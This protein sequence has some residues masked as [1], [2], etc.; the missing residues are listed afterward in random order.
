MSGNGAQDARIGEARASGPGAAP[1][2]A[3][4]TGLG[5]QVRISTLRG[6]VPVLALVAGDLVLTR[7]SGFR[8]V[9][10][11]GQAEHG[12]AAGRNHPVVAVT[13][14]DHLG[15]GSADDR[16]DTRP[17]A[18]TRNIGPV[19]VDCS[20]PITSVLLVLDRHS[21]VLADGSWT[22]THSPMQL[23]ALVAQAQAPDIHRR[24]A[25]LWRDDRP[26]RLVLVSAGTVPGIPGAG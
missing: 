13:A 5:P 14:P 23:E 11:A 16:A 8:P 25:E 20:E 4:V 12:I 18:I 19:A 3:Q 21:Q 15:S 6:L 10:W 1:S 9:L 24:I 2:P 7:D 17:I 26:V 22:E